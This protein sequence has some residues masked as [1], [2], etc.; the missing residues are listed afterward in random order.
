MGKTYNHANVG[1]DP[2]DLGKGTPCKDEQTGG[3]HYPCETSGVKPRFGS[4]FGKVF[5]KVNGLVSYKGWDRSG[6]PIQSI[7]AIGRR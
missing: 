4:A 5:P 6:A 3:E 1:P 7:L 2:V